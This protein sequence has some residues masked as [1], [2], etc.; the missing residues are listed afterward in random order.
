MGSDF[1]CISLAESQQCPSLSS[2]SIS[3]TPQFANI[4]SFDSYVASSSENSTAFVSGFAEVFA[5]PAFDGHYIRY[6]RSLMCYYFVSL[7]LQQGCKNSQPFKPLC[8][9]SCEAY[10]A[11]VEAVFGNRDIC[12]PNAATSDRESFLQTYSSICTVATISPV[13]PQSAD[14][15]PGTPTDVSRNGFLYANDVVTSEVIA[16]PV[17]STNRKMDD[18]FITGK[19]LTRAQ[20]LAL[21]LPARDLPWILSG[22]VW[23]TG[24]FIF[25]FYALLLHFCVDWNAYSTYSV[26]PKGMTE[27]PERAARRRSEEV[28]QPYTIARGAKYQRTASERRRSLFYEMFE[29]RN[30]VVRASVRSFLNPSRQTRDNVYIEPV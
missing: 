3:S 26:Q 20:K 11:S 23:A 29:S 18:A 16:F 28:F 17:I 2:Y 30:S 14:C 9:S 25:L 13:M 22:A 24:S 27:T 4:E 21:V 6:H 5:C 12:T 8:Q 15:D 19:P 1:V 7:G 10:L